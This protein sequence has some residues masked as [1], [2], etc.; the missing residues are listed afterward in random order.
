MATFLGVREAIT[1]PERPGR[2]G[3]VKTNKGENAVDVA[4]QTAETDINAAY[5]DAIHVLSTKPLERRKAGCSNF[6]VRLLPQLPD[7][8]CGVSPSF[9]S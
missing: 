2:P 6:V 1:R 7:K 5:E 4:V 8:V 9:L 3:V